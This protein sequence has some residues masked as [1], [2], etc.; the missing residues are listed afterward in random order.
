LLGIIDPA[1]VQ[2]PML[3]NLKR[4]QF[5]RCTVVS[6]PDSFRFPAPRQPIEL[7]GRPLLRRTEIGRQ[8]A[9]ESLLAIAESALKILPLLLC[10]TAALG[11][12]MFSGMS[13]T[14]I[15]HI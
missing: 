7:V 3:L 15:N 6:A 11:H 13:I 12:I 8:A 4:S 10:V 1:I 9:I 5:P 2:R 14:F